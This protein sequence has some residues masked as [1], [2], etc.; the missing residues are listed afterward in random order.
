[1]EGPGQAKGQAGGVGELIFLV[2][3]AATMAASVGAAL[4]GH[5]GSDYDL[6]LWES[7]AC[8]LDLFSIPHA[9]GIVSLVSNAP[10]ALRDAAAEAQAAVALNSL[11]AAIAADATAWAAP[12]VRLARWL[13]RAAADA[14]FVPVD[15]CAGAL[16]DAGSAVE[17]ARGWCLFAF[18]FIDRFAQGLA[19]DEALASLADLAG[20]P[21]G[22]THRLPLR[23][24][25]L[26]VALTGPGDGSVAYFVGVHMDATWDGAVDWA[27]AAWQAR[28]AAAASGWS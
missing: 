19:L 14:Y 20:L 3:T 16:S 21:S 27:R 10:S 24:V 5:E 9:W 8:A 12:L 25:K 2:L 6:V 26:A 7:T 17:C 1:M 15:E 28:G 4:A 13:C 18:I 23:L 11:A 22:R